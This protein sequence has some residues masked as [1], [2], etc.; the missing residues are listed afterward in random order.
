MSLAKPY[1]FSSGTIIASAQVNADF[2]ALFTAIGNQ[3]YTEEN[4]VSDDQTVTASLDAI[5]I[6][7]KDHDDNFSRHLYGAMQRALFTYNG[8]ATAYTVLVGAAAYLCKEKFCYWNSE[9]TTGAISSPVADTRYYLYLDYSAITSGTAITATE[10]IWS[11]TAPTWNGTYRG[12]YNSDDRCIFG[13][14][15]NGTPTNIAEF[16][17]DGGD[18]VAWG[19][20]A[21]EASTVDP[22]TSWTDCDMATSVPAFSTKATIAAHWWLS[23]PETPPS[24]LW[25][26]NGSTATYGNILLDL[27]SAASTYGGGDWSSISAV[28][29]DASQ[30]FEIRAS[31]ASDYVYDIRCLGW[32]FPNG[33]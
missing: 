20:Y 33:M 23:S 14:I 16:W 12:W 8:G 28:F 24:L 2:D 19:D 18:Y 32:Y 27:D 1:T 6:K 15:T 5:D 3:M 25:R 13:V 29:L 21:T 30:I 26:K 10:L 7:L 22:D 31:S 17:H 11:T 4:Y 9:L